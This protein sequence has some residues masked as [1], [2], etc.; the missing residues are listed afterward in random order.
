MLRSHTEYYHR[1]LTS[2]TYQSDSIT[3]ALCLYEAWQGLCRGKYCPAQ[4]NGMMLVHCVLFLGV[5]INVCLKQPVGFI[6]SV[7]RLPV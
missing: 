3:Q 7:C 1:Q 2:Q 6:L 5:T 4:G